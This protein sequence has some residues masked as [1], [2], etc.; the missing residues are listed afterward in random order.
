MSR[1]VSALSAGI[2]MVPELNIRN[3]VIALVNTRVKITFRLPTL[4]F[5]PSRKL[6]LFF[7]SLFFDVAGH[8]IVALQY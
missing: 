6:T 5:F 1:V 8:R 7:F 4:G 3:P 2:I